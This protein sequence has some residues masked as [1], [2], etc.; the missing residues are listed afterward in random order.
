MTEDEIWEA[1]QLA[2]RL[3]R[4]AEAGLVKPEDDRDNAILLKAIRIFDAKFEH[5]Q[6]D[7]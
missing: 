2:E 1:A 3:L 4:A 7:E 6:D 5:E